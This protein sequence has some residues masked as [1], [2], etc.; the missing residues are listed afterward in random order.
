MSVSALFEIGIGPSCSHE[1]GPMR[2]WFTFCFCLE[3]K[4]LV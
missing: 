3:Q 1:V 2:A 4:Q